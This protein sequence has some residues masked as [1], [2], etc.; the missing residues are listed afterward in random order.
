MMFNDFLALP[1][2]TS[3]FPY[4]IAC[5]CRLAK[6]TSCVGYECLR[7]PTYILFR[8]MTYWGLLQFLF[9]P[10]LSF[11]SLLHLLMCLVFPYVFVLLLLSSSFFYS[12]TLRTSLLVVKSN[13]PAVLCL[14][15]SRF[16]T[17]VWSWHGCGSCIKP[18]Y[19]F[20]RLPY[21]SIVTIR[22]T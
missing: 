12:R 1:S 22:I 6:I 19:L 18:R 13:F 20:Y 10:L 15:R 21:P 5:S 8:N 2:D 3:S 4:L 17:V 14:S 9:F 11:L 7:C 16:T